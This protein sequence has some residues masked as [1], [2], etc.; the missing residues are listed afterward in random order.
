MKNLLFI[1]IAF[2]ILFLF[3]CEKEAEEICESTKI[4]EQGLSESSKFGYLPYL[5]GQ[6]INFTN[7]AGET[8]AFTAQVEQNMDNRICFRELCEAFSSPTS[9]PICEFYE[10]ESLKNTLT[11]EDGSISIALEASIYSYPQ[12]A[13]SFLDLFTMVGRTQGR[14][15][16][17]VTQISGSTYDGTIN[18]PSSYP[19]INIFIRGG[20]IT[21]NGIEFSSVF[22]T[23]I[24]DDMLFYQLGRGVVGMSIAGDTL[25][26]N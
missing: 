2:G 12:G 3:S 20:D 8:I 10:T 23:E 13:T 1:C 15:I 5:A 19:P 14:T 25:V 16:G 21:L 26:I 7:E 17:N 24:A 18:Y 6:Q 11:S 9:A 4:G 22:H